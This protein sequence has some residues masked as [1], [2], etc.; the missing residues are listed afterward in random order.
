MSGRNDGGPAYPHEADYVM[1]DK[2]SDPYQFKVDFHP[3]MSLR[4]YF[5]G[6]ALANSWTCLEK[7]DQPEEI[8]KDAYKIADAMLAEREKGGDQ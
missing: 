2:P 3:G 4:D 6:Q 8:A 7:G 5:A 1:G